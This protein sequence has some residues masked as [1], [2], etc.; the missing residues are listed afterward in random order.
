MT[1]TDAA[2]ALGVSASA[3]KMRV[4][5]ARARLVALLGAGREHVAALVEVARVHAPM[6]TLRGGTNEVLRGMVARGMGLR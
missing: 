2:E 6:F 3:V 1:M 4:S 5:R